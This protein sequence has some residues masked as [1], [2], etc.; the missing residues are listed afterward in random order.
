MGSSPIEIQIL[1]AT[2]SPLVLASLEPHVQEEADRLFWF[3]LRENDVH[4]QLYP[5]AKHGDVIGWLTS[6]IF[7]LKEARSLEAEVVL[8]AAEA[9]MAADAEAQPENLRTEENIQQEMRRV[10]PGD[11]PIWSRWLL[12]TQGGIPQ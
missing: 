12:K 6:P 2:H 11:D 10:L 1:T 3:D 5:W 7:G 9:F 8:D 4:F